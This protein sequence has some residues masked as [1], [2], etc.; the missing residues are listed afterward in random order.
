MCQ[1]AY[2]MRRLSCPYPC[3]STGGGFCTPLDRAQPRSSRTS[4]QCAMPRLSLVQ[5]CLV[6]TR[7]WPG[8]ALPE[9]GCMCYWPRATGRFRYEAV[10]PRTYVRRKTAPPGN[11]EPKMVRFSAK[12]TISINSSRPKKTLGGGGGDSPGSLDANMRR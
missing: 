6:A 1:G 7:D 3:R 10:R 12:P 2:H 8:A 9:P 5:V 11:N 4:R